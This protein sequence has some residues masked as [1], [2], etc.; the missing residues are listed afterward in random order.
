M[1]KIE[2]IIGGITFALVG[3]VGYFIGKSERNKE[4]DSRLAD[5]CEFYQN[6]SRKQ[7]AQI[8]RIQDRLV[9][10]SVDE[11]EDFLDFMRDK[12][13]FNVKGTYPV[14]CIVNPLEEVDLKIEEK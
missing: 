3:L 12:D 13:G 9:Y 4:V 11:I 14:L 7:A 2:G 1:N 8:E 6:Q 10:L 5:G